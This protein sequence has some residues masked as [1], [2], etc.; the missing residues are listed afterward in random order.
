MWAF[1]PSIPSIKREMPSRYRLE[2]FECRDC[3]FRSLPPRQVCPR[4]GSRNVSRVRLPR[5]G[6]VLQH[7][8]VRSAPRGYEF[9]T[10]YALALIELEDGTRL[11][12]QLTD[13]DPEEV[14]QGM[15]VEA[16]L[17][18]VRVGGHGGPVAY[19]LKFRPVLKR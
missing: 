11:F 1:N 16:A 10:P 17:R 14:T 12:S 4:C 13:V 3:G 8:V 19:G 15:E 9:Y 5:R 7:T 6:R 18:K 2:G